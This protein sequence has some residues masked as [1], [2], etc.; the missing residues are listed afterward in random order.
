VSVPLVERL[1]EAPTTITAARVSSGVP[2]APGFYAWWLGDRRALPDVPT[3]PHPTDPS[4]GLAYLGI[5]P[6]GP[7]S[8]ATIRSRVLGNHLG[9]ALGSSTFRR[10]LAALLWE[11]EGWEP[12]L[13]GKKAAFAPEQN[14]ALTRWMETNMLVSWCR[15]EEA[16]RHEAELIAEMLPP[17]NSD[18]NHDH[19][20]YPTIKAARAQFMTVARANRL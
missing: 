1:T 16:W 14:Q 3:S 7:S 4:L 13:K 6:N 10:A 15:A 20:F 17:L 11:R 19:P 8:A 9:N 18:D 12:I 2:A 5:A